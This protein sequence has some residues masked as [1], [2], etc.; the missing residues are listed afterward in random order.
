MVEKPNV[1]WN[2]IAGLES[3]KSALHEIVVLPNLRPELFTG[4]RSPARGVLL[5]G[6]PGT[7]ND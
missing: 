1:A 6:P 5:F 7:G 4:L 2:D 3:A